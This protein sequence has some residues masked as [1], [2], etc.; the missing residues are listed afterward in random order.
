M[1]VDPKE[2]C[3]TP[4]P[5][6]LPR[7][8]AL[9][10][11]AAAGLG[12][13]LVGGGLLELFRQRRLHR[14]EMTRLGMGTPIS[15][16][17]VHPDPDVA[18]QWVNAAFD[19]IER[20]ESILSRYRP[21][22][23]LSELNRAGQIGNPPRELAIVVERALHWASETGGAFDPTISSVLELH[24]RTS[25][26]AAGPTSSELRAALEHVGWEEVRA[27]ATGIHLRPRMA[28]TL[29]GIAK[30][31]VVD[32]VVSELSRRGADQVLVE[33][34]GDLATLSVGSAGS[35]W[36]IGI[37]D[38]LHPHQILGVIQ[39]PREGAVAS[40][41]GAFETFA[42]GNPNHHLLDPRTGVSPERVKGVTVSAPTAMDADALATA[43]F[44]L[45]PER[46]VEF[47]DR[48][49]GVEGM[50]IGGEGET[51]RSQGFERLLV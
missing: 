20:L 5:R 22:S 41:S 28:L 43:V 12:G 24:R 45:G 40:S 14:V 11:A 50:V 18:R 44:V 16:A 23:P 48:V 1:S 34:G 2:V 26:T 8:Q 17:V 31:F 36:R 37:Q 10:I 49:P 4:G 47:L 46:G 13:V 39:Q 51:W 3:F 19:Q 15:M 6:P 35:G 29:D 30:G 25:Q 32:E 27:S 7:R 42:P 38:P 33:A 9:R 21:E